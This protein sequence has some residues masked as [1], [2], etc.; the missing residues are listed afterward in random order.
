[1]GIPPLQILRAHNQY[2]YRFYELSGDLPDALH[3]RHFEKVEPQDSLTL[4]K[5]IR[6]QEDQPRETL[7]IR[8]KRIKLHE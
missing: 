4:R 7:T 8:K 2:E 1:L 5:R 6:I 3:F